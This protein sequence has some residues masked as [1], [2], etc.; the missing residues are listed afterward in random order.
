[1]TFVVPV[2]SGAPKDFKLTPG[3]HT[4]IL[5]Y[6]NADNFTGFHSKTAKTEITLP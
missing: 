2:N 3:K 6:S 5:G 4:V 1:M